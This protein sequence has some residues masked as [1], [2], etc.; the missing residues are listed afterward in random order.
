MAALFRREGIGLADPHE[1]S[2]HSS[3]QLHNQIEPTR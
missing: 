1:K 2:P 3:L